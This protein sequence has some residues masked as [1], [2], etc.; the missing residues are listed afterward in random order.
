MTPQPTTELSPTLTAKINEILA[1]EDGFKN[2]VKWEVGSPSGL[3]G[4]PK[5]DDRLL[6]V[7]NYTLDSSRHLIV[8]LVGRLSAKEFDHFRGEL[9]ISD[10]VGQFDLGSD[11]EF[12]AMFLAPVLTLIKCYFAAKGLKWPEE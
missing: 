10:G 3:V 5:G 7:P 11:E 9:E 4:Y 1:R 12:R 6:G 8:A 2:I